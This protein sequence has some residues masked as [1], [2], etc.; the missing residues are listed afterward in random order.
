MA[1][2]GF[3]LIIFAALIALALIDKVVQAQGGEI[4]PT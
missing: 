2:A 4:P 1:A 3:A